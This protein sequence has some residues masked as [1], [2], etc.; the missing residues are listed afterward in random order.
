MRT[1][2]AFSATAFVLS[3]AM[4]AAPRSTAAD[5]PP[6][7]LE[8]FSKGVATLNAA[9][10]AAGG[11]QALRGVAS[12]SFTARGDTY[13]DVQGFSAANIG[14]PERD[15]RLT[16]VN[17]FDFAGARF[18]QRTLQEL[19]GGFAIDT[20]TLFRNGTSY[21]LRNNGREYVQ[22]ANAPSPVGAGGLLT[23]V[24]RFSPPL[25]LQRALQNARSVA[26]VG[27]SNAGGGADVVEFSFDEAT[28]FRLHVTKSDRRVARLE[29]VA[30]D[31]VAGDDVGVVEYSGVQKVG[32]LAFPLRL[33]TFRRGARTFDLAVE[34][35]AVNPTLDDALFQP[36]ATYR[37]VSDDKVSTK[38][39]N[40]RVY[41]VSGLGGG[42]YRSQ[43]I[44]MDD[45]VIAFEAPLG[46]PAT[47]QIIGEIKKVAGDK[48]IRYVVISHFH[49]DHAGGVGAYTDLGATV[50]SAAEN[51]DVLRAYARSRSL[52]QG[53]GGNRA[54]VQLAFQ[55]VG[56]EGFEIADAG[57]HRVRVINFQTP[58]VERLLAL[59]EPETRIVI[60]GDMFSRLVR[61]NKTFDVFAKW[62]KRNEPP[63]ELIL[64][65]HHEPITREEL[66][67]VARGR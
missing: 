44:V 57:G 29:S 7:M 30:P 51:Q 6:G 35:V 37:V 23:I 39:I 54:D 14:K 59:Y 28:R 41:E 61:W 10:D 15:G 42:N 32:G 25:L 4:L 62:L 55:P 64:G 8:R 40:G 56:A 1:G 49:S 12:I 27:E 50:V 63:V 65:T 48:P 19:A 21:A 45:F 9:A 22:T 38:Q 66:L 18:A 13:N 36:P 24:S 33:A 47:R 43:F 2:F 26:W 17:D 5:A 46:I 60:N 67:V 3:V 52:L 11:A 16:V 58:H 20:S 34:K 31:A 53:L